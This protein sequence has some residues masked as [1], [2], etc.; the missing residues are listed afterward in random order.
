MVPTMKK[1]TAMSSHAAKL[2][3][4]HS[5]KRRSHAWRRA[6][7]I[8]ALAAALLAGLGSAEN[9]H[10]QSVFGDLPKAYAAP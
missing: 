8:A 3:G 1:K 5:H 7:L 10:E 9:S 6:F 2:H 4:F